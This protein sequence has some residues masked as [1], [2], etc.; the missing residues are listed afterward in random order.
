V[1]T[2]VGA[3][4]NVL[5]VTFPAGTSPVQTVY[6]VTAAPGNI[7][8]TAT[9][10]TTTVGLSSASTV[11]AH[12][13]IGHWL[14]GANNLSDTSGFT[15]PGTHDGVV[16]G[17][18][19]A[20]LAYS[21]DVPPGFTGQSLDLTANGSGANIGVAI[22][23]SSINDAAYQSTF[24]GAIATA[25]TVAYWEKGVPG[26]FNPY[27]SKAGENNI[28]W[29]ARVGFNDYAFT[30]RGSD[31]N[32]SDGTS[33]FN[34]DSNWHQVTEV[35]D[36]VSGIRQIYVDGVMRLNLAGDYGPMYQAPAEHLAIGARENASGWENAWFNG[37]IYDV[38]VYN[39]PLSAGEVAA[40]TGV[41]TAPALTIARGAGNT[42]LLSWTNT[43]TGY[44]IQT[45]SSLTGTWGTPSLTTVNQAGQFTATDSSTN[46]TEFYR[47]FKT[48]N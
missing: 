22:T 3:I 39:Y 2:L 40:L 19:P 14:S 9:M 28:G 35:W 31:N 30:I 45:N 23:N 26:F 6:V 44:V 32:N 5:T 4:N 17:S 37:L 16:V 18:N 47:L 43:T 36:G 20:S 29:E 41:A 7:N 11:Y 1:A 8:I 34:A 25:F 48:G 46:K 10:E 42:V 12:A 24:D 27:V 33:G 38:R 13:L 21:S 15:P